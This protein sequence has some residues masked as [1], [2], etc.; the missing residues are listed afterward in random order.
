ML[1]RCISA[2]DE[3]ARAAAAGSKKKVV[4]PFRDS[5]L[6]LYLRESL[7]GNAKTTMLACVSP[8][9]TNRDETLSTLRYAYSAKQIVTKA[10]KRCEEERAKGPPRTHRALILKAQGTM[11]L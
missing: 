9:G 1:G 3:A 5:K 6:T 2:L 10:V 4:P 7:A 11:L 8:A